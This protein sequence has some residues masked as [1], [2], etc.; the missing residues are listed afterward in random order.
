MARFKYGVSLLALEKKV[1]V[2][3][4]CLSGLSK[5]RPKGSREITPGPVYAQIQKPI[6]L[7]P[8]LSVPD[9][10]RVIY[11]SLNRAMKRVSAFGGPAGQF[12]FENG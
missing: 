2:V 5:T 9:A 3:P 8:G 7:A 4:I 11:N 12:D 6:Y 10:T 1:P